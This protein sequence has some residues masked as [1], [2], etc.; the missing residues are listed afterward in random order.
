[1]SFQGSG[2]ARSGGSE[3]VLDGAAINAAAKTRHL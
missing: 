3:A 2:L 1:M